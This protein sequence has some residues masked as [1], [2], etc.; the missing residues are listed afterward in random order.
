MSITMIMD[1][2]SESLQ[3]GWIQTKSSKFSIHYGV[4]FASMTFMNWYMHKRMHTN[5]QSCCCFLTFD[6]HLILMNSCSGVGRY[7]LGPDKRFVKYQADAHLESFEQLGV[8][9]GKVMQY[10]SM[11][12]MRYV[13]QHYSILSYKYTFSFG[14]IDS[15]NFQLFNRIGIQCRR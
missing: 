14:I 8:F 5:L 3:V 7:V 4:L 11:Q 10:M 9:S 1:L 13:Y 6:I 2:Y 12:Y 15:N